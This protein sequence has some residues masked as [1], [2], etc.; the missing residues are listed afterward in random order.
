MPNSADTV[1]L[2][3]SPP[4]VPDALVTTREIFH[5]CQSAFSKSAQIGGRRQISRSGVNPDA[6][7]A[8]NAIAEGR[9]RANKVERSCQG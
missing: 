2:V 3:S 6:V 7:A 5:C 1:H 4:A 8:S 9:I